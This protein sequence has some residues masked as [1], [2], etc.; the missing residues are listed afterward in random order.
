MSDGEA[1]TLIILALLLQLIVAGTAGYGACKLMNVETGVVKSILLGIVGAFLGNILMS[2]LG[3]Y[4][5]GVVGVI[6]TAGL[7][8]VIFIFIFNEFFESKSSRRN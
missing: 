5:S 3:I 2:I 6:L 4:V 7:G 8:A 1:T